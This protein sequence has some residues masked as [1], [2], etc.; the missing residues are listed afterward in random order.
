[1][2]FEV[3]IDKKFAFMIFGAILILAGA[4]YGYAYGGNTPAVMGHSLGE[5][6]VETSYSCGAGE[7]LKS[8]DLETGGVVCETDDVGSGESGPGTSCS[9]GEMEEHSF[10]QEYVATTDG[11]VM[12]TQKYVSGWPVMIVYINGEFL[13]QE[14]GDDDGGKQASLTFS[15]KMGDIWKVSLNGN[16]MDRNLQWMPFECGISELEGELSQG[17][18]TWRKVID[19]CSSPDSDPPFEKTCNSNEF[20]AGIKVRGGDGNCG[21]LKNF[22]YINCC[23][24]SISL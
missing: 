8:I 24:I 14:G 5:I 4:I 16:S 9:F 1:M 13:M 22:V 12:A 6:D 7:Y 20:M 3:N 21:R 15:V 10:N 23:T 19:V 17:T 11:I 18:C 2:K